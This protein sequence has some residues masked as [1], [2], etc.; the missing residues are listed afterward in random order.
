MKSKSIAKH[1]QKVEEYLTLSK[2]LTDKNS[3][4]ELKRKMQKD[5]FTFYNDQCEVQYTKHVEIK[6]AL[7]QLSNKHREILKNMILK[8]KESSDLT[9]DFFSSIILPEQ[10][11][12][13]KFI[14]EIIKNPELFENEGK[15]YPYFNENGTIIAISP[16]D[17]INMLFCESFVNDIFTIQ[18]LCVVRDCVDD[19]MFIT[20]LKLKYNN[21]ET[22]KNKFIR[23][24][25]EKICLIY[26]DLY[27]D[28][29][30]DENKQQL[31][32]LIETVKTK[33]NEKKEHHSE[34]KTRK[35]VNVL[36]QKSERKSEMKTEIIKESKTIKSEMKE[37]KETKE[38]K[39]KQPNLMCASV[40]NQSMFISRFNNVEMAQLRKK[41]SVTTKSMLS[42]DKFISKQVDDKFD[43]KEIHIPIDI[44]YTDLKNNS[45]HAKFENIKCDV[46]AKQLFIYDMKLLQNISL[47]DVI[48]RRHNF[49]HY[50]DVIEFIAKMV[51]N[52]IMN[53]GES[54]FNH[55][56]EIAYESYKI[57]SF[58]MA[59]VI[60]FGLNFCDN[61]KYQLTTQNKKLYSELKEIFSHT[62]F[63]R[64]K[65][66][67]ISFTSGIKIPVVVSHINAVI[68]RN[69]DKK[70]VL[71]DN[72][73]NNRQ[74]ASRMEDIG[75]WL[76]FL[77]VAQNST[78]QFEEL[79]GLQSY[80]ETLQNNKALQKQSLKDRCE[81]IRN[82]LAFLHHCIQKPSKESGFYLNEGNEINFVLQHRIQS[83]LGIFFIMKNGVVSCIF[84]DSSILTFYNNEY[85]YIERNGKETIIFT[86]ETI[87]DKER[88]KKR[89]IIDKVQQQFMN[90]L[91][92]SEELQIDTEHNYQTTMV[93]EFKKKKD[94]I[95]FRFVDGTIH[96]M[97][98][99]SDLSYLITPQNE[100]ISIIQN[101]KRIVECNVD[102][103]EI[104]D[105][106]D[107][108]IEHLDSVEFLLRSIISK[109]DTK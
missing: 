7:F 19:D 38:H 22:V 5:H 93:K 67:F 79:N 107:L 21:P 45:Q 92:K 4:I 75:K 73:Y 84:N 82:S 68:I 105:H 85:H 12:N 91:K 98:N 1:N 102:N 78:I 96:V 58:N 66:E 64:Y 101:G 97:F 24:Q 90:V 86:A 65:Q 16:H 34:T 77:F 6:Y 70:Y 72:E 94:Y 23:R 3:L 106:D 56:I 50:S 29:M 10:I 99:N 46:V 54:M 27:Q 40:M 41:S 52:Y 20:V 39:E 104:G 59:S 83:N 25:V 2:S 108:V 30:S 33:K 62:D 49:V 51:R 26:L 74:F 89:D 80:F 76:A 95:Y 47:I 32:E 63:E 88:K 55:F 15:F 36:E 11:K 100:K 61:G 14:E 28:F 48:K 42:I 18:I 13:L 17:A 87:L 103:K 35:S 81:S 57:G 53:R 44:E 31:I 109:L 8:M 37:K 43:I 71:N 60:V 69:E 9:A